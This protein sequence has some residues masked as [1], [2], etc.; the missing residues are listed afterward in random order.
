MSLVI[1]TTGTTVLVSALLS[2]VHSHVL[3]DYDDRDDC[4]NISVAVR[5]AQPCPW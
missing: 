3:G 4:V 5:C 2:G 1:A